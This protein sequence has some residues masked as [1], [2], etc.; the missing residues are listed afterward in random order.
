MN[1]EVHFIMI[2]GSVHQEDIII[3]NVHA[4]LHKFTITV[5]NFNTP[6]LIIHTTRIQKVNK[7]VKDLNNIIDQNNLIDI[8]RTPHPTK[9]ETIE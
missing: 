9:I 1:R 5:G 8:H 7:I 4:V 2:K 3:F 6:L